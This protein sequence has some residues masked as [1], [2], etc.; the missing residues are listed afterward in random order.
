MTI[1]REQKEIKVQFDDGA[2]P[3]ERAHALDAGYD[4]RTPKDFVVRAKSSAT[5]DTGVHVQIPNGFVGFL[6]SKSGLNVRC[7]LTGTGVIDAGYTGSIKV[8]LYNHGD[9]DRFFNR[10][11]KIIQLVILPIITPDLKQVEK[12]DETERG[13]NGFGSTGR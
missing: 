6:K 12:L 7:D 3:M 8:K 9:K 10:G 2:F 13:N 11:D 1:P 5:I 4:L